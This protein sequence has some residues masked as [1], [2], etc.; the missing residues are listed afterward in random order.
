MGICTAAARRRVDEN[1]YAK[2]ATGMRSAAIAS[3]KIL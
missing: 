2:G 1:L 3:G